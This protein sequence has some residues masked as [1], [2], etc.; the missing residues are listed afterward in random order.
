MT[1]R[2]HRTAVCVGDFARVSGFK[3]EKH[4]LRSVATNR[5][6]VAPY[7]VARDDRLVAGQ[8]RVQTLHF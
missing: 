2:E 6:Q 3:I 5:E 4:R 8:S 7:V 1:T